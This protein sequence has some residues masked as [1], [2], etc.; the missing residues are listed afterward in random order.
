LSSD[1][2]GI[3]DFDG[4]LIQLNPA[5]EAVLGHSSDELMARPFLDFI[6]AD[7]YKK[8]DAEIKRLSAGHTT[9]DFENRYIHKDG[10]VRYI[11]W[12]ATPLPEEGLF[13][14]IG[15][16][17][18]QRKKSEEQIISYQQ[19][20]KDL[21]E[22]LTLSEEKQNKLIAT[23]LHDHVGQL[24]ASSRLQLAALHDDM[25]KTEILS[26][27]GQISRGLLQAIQATREVI[28]DLSPPQLNEI[29]L[30][31]AT[32]DWMDEEV[33]TKHGIKARITGDDRVYNI[34]DNMRILLFRSIRELLMNVV[35]HA[36]AN[37][38]DVN[39]SERAKDLN[40]TVKDDG[41][42]FSY[43]PE[44]LRLRSSGF[45]LF[46]IQER[47]ANYGGYMSIESSPG[48]G[49]AITLSFPLSGSVS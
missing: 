20:L 15:R 29:G 10:S 4:N 48:K 42:G 41:K 5:W 1:L 23:N 39:I 14:C 46:S 8:S 38:V 19:R 37:R 26:K 27:T 13:Y 6:H 7:D 47:V 2:I 18:T 28:F 32:S 40:I 16:D 24:L 11:S 35:K 9:I 34:D 44:M 21:A 12:T 3:G 36:R 49:T 30:Y 22:Q 43:N 31:A 45:G 25:S 33:E 17:I